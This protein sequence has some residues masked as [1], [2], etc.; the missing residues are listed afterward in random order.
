MIALT[1]ILS[2]FSRHSCGQSAGSLIVAFSL[3]FGL[4]IEA[5]AQDSW[6]VAMAQEHEG[7]E[8]VASGAATMAPR[9]EVVSERV[10]YASEGMEATGYLA[11]PKD[12]DVL[13]EIGRQSS[14]SARA[15]EMRSLIEKTVGHDD[16]RDRQ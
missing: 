5:S 2:P 4:S 11:R 13:R 9:V 1:R 10:V 8:P 15:R 16:G 3:F 12:A 7:D 6:V 14:W